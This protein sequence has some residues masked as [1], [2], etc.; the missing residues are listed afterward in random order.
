M[1]ELTSLGFSAT[2][3]QCHIK[4]KSLMRTYNAAKDNQ[5]KTGRGPSRFQFCDEIGLI[6]G[7]KPSNQC[8]HTHWVV[9]LV[10]I[11]LILIVRLQIKTTQ[12]ALVI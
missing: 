7:S 9:L 5:Q 6:V 10:L 8:E 4:W 11:L 12:L 1:N 2:A 3:I